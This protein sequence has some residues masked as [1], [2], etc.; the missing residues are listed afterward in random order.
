MADNDP[1]T[2]AAVR[3]VGELIKAPS[4]SPD[5]RAVW[6]RASQISTHDRKTINVAVLPRFRRS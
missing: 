1:A 5:V 6:G 4:D 2:A 3:M